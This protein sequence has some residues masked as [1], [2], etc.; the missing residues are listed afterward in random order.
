MCRSCIQAGS[1]M[2]NQVS[3]SAHFRARAAEYEIPEQMVDLLDRNHIRTMGNM[4]FAF[5]RPGAEFNEAEFTNWIRDLNGG[6]LPAMGIV[7]ALRRLHFESEIILTASLRASVEAPESST[8]KALPFAERSERLQQLRQRLT[9]LNI[10]GAGEPSH[11]LLDEVCAQYEQRT[12]KYLE[13]ARCT[14]R[15][16]EVLTG[17]SDKKLK[18]DPGSLTIRESRSVQDETVSTTHHLAQCLRRRGLAYDFANLMSYRS[19][20]NYVERLLR[21]L[22]VDPPP[23]YQATTMTQVLRADKEVFTFLSQRVQDIR[24]RPDGS[25]PLDEELV[26]ALQNYNTTFHLLPLPKASVP[27]VVA[28]TS[29]KSKSE[30]YVS[31]YNEAPAWKGKGKGKARGKGKG[32]NSAPRGMVGCV[33]RDGKNR[34]ICFDFNLSS[35]SAAPAGGAC[36]KGRHVCF[37]AGCFKTHSYASAHKD[38]PKNA[39]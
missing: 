39:E 31:N 21:H 16:N 23:G 12:L 30:G 33:G 1:E 26:N 11:S 18:L 19:H 6:N 38:A 29:N 37:K 22:D 9:G 8:P 34:P 35:C 2:S 4:A 32:S 24:P 36:P 25:R 17:K 3:S 13:P 5:S 20:D 28:A 27:E 10:E 14:S 7:A 15:E